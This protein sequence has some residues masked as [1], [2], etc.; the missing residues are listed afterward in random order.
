MFL[1]V[2]ACLMLCREGY[3]EI[4]RY[5]SRAIPQVILSHG[6][7]AYWTPFRLFT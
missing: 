1:L 2:L 5:F 4:V 6:T 3:W 7:V